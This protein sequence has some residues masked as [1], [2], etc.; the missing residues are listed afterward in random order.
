MYKL[1]VIVEFYQLPILNLI[2]LL[3]VM[4]NANNNSLT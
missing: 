3:I 1:W 4:A 2:V